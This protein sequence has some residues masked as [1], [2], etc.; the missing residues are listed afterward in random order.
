MA[1]RAAGATEPARAATLEVVGLRYNAPLHELTT[2][3]VVRQEGKHYWFDDERFARKVETPQF[4]MVG[5][6]VIAAIFVLFV[7]AL[8]GVL[9]AS[10]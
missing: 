3:G 1:F 8:V 7:V 4:R 2:L 9:S 10:T 5:M 6:I